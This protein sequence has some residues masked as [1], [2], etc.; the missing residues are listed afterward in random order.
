MTGKAFHREVESDDGSRSGEYGW[1]DPIGVRR[2]V[3]Y[4]TGPR[5]GILFRH[6]LR[7]CVLTKSNQWPLVAF[8]K[9][10]KGTAFS[11]SSLTYGGRW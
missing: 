3:E 1:I 10:L 11:G 5:Q 8:F 4:T 7:G 6:I 2:V 9:N